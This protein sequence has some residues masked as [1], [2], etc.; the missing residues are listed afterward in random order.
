MWLG[1]LPVQPGNMQGGRG[2]LTGGA[3]V[4]V[5]GEG[6]QGRRHSWRARTR[7]GA[8]LCQRTQ[9]GRAAVRLEGT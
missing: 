4:Q 8:C 9:V 6:C 7:G 2:G 3:L 5:G 1:N